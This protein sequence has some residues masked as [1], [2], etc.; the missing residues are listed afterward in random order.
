MMAFST[1]LIFKWL[2]FN[3]MMDSN[4]NATLSF[5][6]KGSLL[7][8]GL[9]GAGAVIGFGREVFLQALWNP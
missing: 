2:I 6:S 8:L 7:I 3:D 4:C 9:G 5:A 1:L